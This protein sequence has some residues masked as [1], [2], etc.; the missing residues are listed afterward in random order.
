MSRTTACIMRINK[1]LERISGLDC[2]VADLLEIEEKR[3]SEMV[4][5]VLKDF[6][7]T[8]NECSDVAHCGTEKCE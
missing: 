8:C 3:I 1:Q 5:T 7:E 2:Y 4:E 6:N